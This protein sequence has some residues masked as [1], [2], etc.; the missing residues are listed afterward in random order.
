[1]TMKNRINNWLNA[2]NVIF[3]ALGEEDDFTNREVL[4]THIITAILLAII[5]VV[6]SILN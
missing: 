1:M 5:I 4:L 3:S 6:G 2:K